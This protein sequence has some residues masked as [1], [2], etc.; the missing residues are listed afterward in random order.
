MV[1]DGTGEGEASD[2]EM[3]AGRKHA[4]TG[5]LPPEHDRGAPACIR[6]IVKQVHSKRNCRRSNASSFSLMGNPPP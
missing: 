2:T 4:P 1:T 3:A 6:P 5:F